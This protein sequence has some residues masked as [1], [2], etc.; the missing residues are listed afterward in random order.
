MFRNGHLWLPRQGTR[1]DSCSLND[2][3]PGISVGDQIA[4]EPGGAPAQPVFRCL[5]E[6]GR[7]CRRPR[8]KCLPRIGS[9]ARPVL[10]R[11]QALRTGSLTGG[12]PLSGLA[13]STGMIRSGTAPS[14][15]PAGW[16]ASVQGNNSVVGVEEVM[17]D[18]SHA[19]TAAVDSDRWRSGRTARRCSPAQA[20]R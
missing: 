11:A 15:T 9:N 10:G 16:C 19:E 5:R 3:T 13:T 18:D 8:L 17:M 1:T 12:D 2:V 14:G 7:G 4:I 6:H 20:Q